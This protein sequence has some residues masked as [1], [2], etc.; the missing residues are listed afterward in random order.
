MNTPFF[1]LNVLQAESPITVTIT[2]YSTAT[3]FTVIETEIMTTQTLTYTTILKTV[4]TVKSTILSITT[5][6]NTISYLSTIYVDTENTD[7]LHQPSGIGSSEL[8]GYVII[9]V[10]LISALSL[11]VL[12]WYIA[13]RQRTV[14]DRWQFFPFLHF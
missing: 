8:G 6:V 11:V 2:S 9:I 7:T 10:S 3:S 13:N 14:F 4:S 12:I 5:L 1:P